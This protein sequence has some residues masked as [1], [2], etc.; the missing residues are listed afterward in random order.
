MARS[1]YIASPEGHTGKSIIALGLV[2]LFVRRVER[3]G[4]FRPVVPAGTERDNVLELLLSHDGVDLPYEDCVGVT[5]D[6]VHA[7]ENAAL[8]RIV[9]RFHAVEQ[10]SDI[11]V[12]V[13]SDYTDVAGP[14]ELAFNGRVA[15]NLGAPVLLAVRALDRTVEE[16]EQVVDIASSE[17]RSDHASIAAVA[18]NRCEPERVDEVQQ[19]LSRLSV[20]VWT[21]PELPLLSA[22]TMG[23]LVEALDGTVIAGDDA[24]LAREAESILVCGMNVEHILER[25]K[26]GQ[27]AIAA[28]D[29]SEVLIALAA[30]HASQNFPSLAGIVLNGGYQPN[31]AVGT[32]VEGLGRSLPI[33]TTEHN[34]YESARIASTTRGLISRGSQRKRDLALSAF[35]RSVDGESV[36]AALDVPRSSVV[37][38][39]MFEAELIERA[40]TDRKH[41][42]LPEGTDDR[43]L[44]AASTLLS[45]GVA[46]LTL[47]GVESDVRGRASELGLDIDAAAVVDPRT[48]ELLEPFAREYTALRAHRGMTME[49]ALE[50]MP[51]VSYFGT[52]MVHLGHADGMVSGA[53]HTTAHTIKPSFEIIKTR[54]GTSIVSSVFLMCLADRVLVYGDCAVNPDPDAEQL[55]DIAISSAETSA[56]FGIEPRIAMLSY[57][58]GTSGSGAEVDK[59]RA[60][61]TIVRESRP[62]LS[63]EGPIQYDAAVD[64]SVAQTKLPESDVAGRATVFIFPDLNTGNN[65]Y[66]AVQRSAGAVAIGPVLQGL[67]KP[68]NDLSRGALVGD[69]VNT[70]AITAIQAQA[71]E[72]QQ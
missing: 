12:I 72:E 59:V 3:V 54:P 67:N 63:V 70:V 61:T 21:F 37:T 60:A 8:S 30:A 53:R 26:E 25:L 45:R 52:M 57:S 35:E 27:V 14:A 58:T 50:I 43:I 40:R 48:S 42:V 18:I 46:D 9:Q 17:L 24:L 23:D 20:P 64:A 19:A 33:V 66:K 36:L 69:I 41:I 11:V 13:G 16:I 32:L 49:R 1:I 47:L 5:Y 10:R 56:Q 29:R 4:I 44:R 38:P 15:A 55:A 65:T 22:A 34:T 68:V 2:D 28:G 7:D 51:S 71:S 6:E 39:L 62:D 31:A